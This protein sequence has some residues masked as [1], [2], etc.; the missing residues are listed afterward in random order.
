MPQEPVDVRHRGSVPE[1]V[2]V[3]EHEHHRLG[4]VSQRVDQHRD[5]E[6]D[7]LRRMEA[8]RRDG[9]RRSSAL[10][11]LQDRTPEAAPVGVAGLQREPARCDLVRALRDPGARQR[12]LAG[13]RAG[14][15]Q[16]Q[17]VLESHVERVGQ[18]RTRD[19][20]GRRARRVEL[21]RLERIELS[22]G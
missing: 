5:H 22:V 18:A 1:L 10:E 15:Q 20:A 12:A 7:R 13:A 17:R 9:L 14:R 8:E 16:R 6:L 19:P 4:Q 3:V 21:R 11:R 2:E